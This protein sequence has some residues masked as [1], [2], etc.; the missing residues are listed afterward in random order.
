M[1]SAPAPLSWT[2]D[3][4]ELLPLALAVGLYARR[5]VV[6]AERGRPVP[7]RCLAAFGAGVTVVALALVSPIDAIGEE[8]LFSVHM[9]QHVLL[10]DLGPLLVV[11]GLDGRLLRPLLA[12]RSVRSLRVL[13]HPAVAL[14]VW[15]VDLCAWHVPVLYD[16]ALR[17]DA[18][19]ACEHALFFVC[20][21]LMWAALFEPLPGPVRFRVPWKGAYLLAMWCV[22]LALSQVFL[23]SG[24]GYYTPY[25]H[26]P[27]TWGLAPLADQRAGGG[28]MLVEG[29]FTMLGVAVW[30]LFRL[31]AES[32]SRQA[33]LDGGADPALA[34]RAS[35]Y[36]RAWTT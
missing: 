18:V 33:L 1:T 31:F 30:L 25:L 9:L 3:P 27:R 6:L 7:K 8:R 26:V 11:L 35:R 10:G 19:H 23:W 32:E 15:A 2:F 34:A 21:G 12:I 24:H 4:L 16:A 28:V 14:P 22:W 17:H 36:G 20:G 13:A 5:A 29:S